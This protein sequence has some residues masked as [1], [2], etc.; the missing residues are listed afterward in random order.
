MGQVAGVQAYLLKGYSRFVPQPGE[1]KKPFGCRCTCE[2]RCSNDITEAGVSGTIYP[3]L[4]RTVPPREKL[5]PPP[6][7]PITLEGL[8]LNKMLL[9]FPILVN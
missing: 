2:V 8:D 7:M 9:L 1:V 4:L 6:P 3:A 5:S